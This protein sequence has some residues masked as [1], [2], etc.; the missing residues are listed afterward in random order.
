MPH[1]SSDMPGFNF[2]AC[3]IIK[4]DASLQINDWVVQQSVCYTR[5]VNICVLSRF[6]CS[7]GDIQYTEANHS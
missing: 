2:L 1:F 7:I 3:L 6:T 4:H 5:Y